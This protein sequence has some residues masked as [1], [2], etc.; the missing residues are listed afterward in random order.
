MEVGTG[1]RLEE[2]DA[3]VLVSLGVLALL[4]PDRVSVVLVPMFDSGVS[5]CLYAWAHERCYESCPETSG[6]EPEPW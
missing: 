6:P 2:P 5:Y 3:A 4:S 1:F